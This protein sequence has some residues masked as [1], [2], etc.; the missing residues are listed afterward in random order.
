MNDLKLVKFIDVFRKLSENI[1]S[2]IAKKGHT[3]FCPV[4]YKNGKGE[5]FRMSF[6]T[7]NFHNLLFDGFPMCYVD[8]NNKESIFLL[9]FYRKPTQLNINILSSRDGN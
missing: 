6:K 3:I 8:T 7:S 9:N 4:E 1:A 5:R 2:D